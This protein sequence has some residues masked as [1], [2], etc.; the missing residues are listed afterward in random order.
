MKAPGFIREER[1][2]TIFVRVEGDWILE[3]GLGRID[4]E[5]RLLSMDSLNQNLIIDL[6]GLGLIDTAGAMMLQRTMRHCGKR[7][8]LTD[9]LHGFE[10]GNA[11]QRKLIERAASVLEDCPVDAPRPSQFIILLDRVGRSAENIIADGL[12][13]T[14]FLGQ[15]LVTL[16]RV[17]AQPKKLR[18]TS[19]VHHMEESGLNATLIVGLMSFMIGAVVAFMGAKIL[20]QFNAS[21]FT[22][23]LIGIS[24]LREF[25]V[26]LT[27]ILIAGRSGSA[28][29]AQ[30]GSMNLNEEIDAMRVIGI[31]PMEALVVP[32]V[33]AMVL[34]LPALAFIAAMMG[35]LGG[36]LVS[37]MVMDI[38]PALFLTRTQDAIVIQNFFV[39]LVKA[40]FFAFVIAVIGCYQGMSVEGSSEN[41]GKRTTMSVVQALFLVIV[42]DAMFAI[43]FLELDI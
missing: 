42:I 41:L 18:V 5:L 14:S 10:G 25:G 43:L 26:L 23:E 31:D 4:K 24:V 28:Y 7:E 38:S 2:D 39:G 13:I 19:L 3:N 36:A 35:L 20:S 1:D 33:L 16:V 9:L 15:T 22:V 8:S 30:L 27:A 6:D 32:R 11:R 21:I 37:W 17:F 34:V 12:A 29:T 40:P